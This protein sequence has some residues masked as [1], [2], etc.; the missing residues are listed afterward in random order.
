[1]THKNRW[2]RWIFIKNACIWGK[3][4]SSSFMHHRH[5]LLTP[6]A[7]LLEWIRYTVYMWSRLCISRVGWTWLNKS[8]SQLPHQLV[9]FCVF[10]DSTVHRYYEIWDE[11]RCFHSP[12]CLVLNYIMNKPWPGF[13][14][15]HAQYHCCIEKMFF[16]R[17]W[18]LGVFDGSQWDVIQITLIRWNKSGIVLSGDILF[19]RYWH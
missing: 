14:S 17:N 6:S 2:N 7:P 8:N 18:P 4:L 13:I 19:I 9:I 10:S 5:V 16:Y 15:A 11:H 3:I 1:M 12:P